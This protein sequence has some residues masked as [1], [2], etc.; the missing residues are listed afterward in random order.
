MYFLVNHSVQH[1]DSYPVHDVD[2]HHRQDIL[3][4]ENVKVELIPFDFA[5]QD[6]EDF[7]KPYAVSQTTLH[8]SVTTDLG[9]KA[10]LC[11]ELPCN[12][13]CAGAGRPIWQHHPESELFHGLRPFQPLEQGGFHPESSQG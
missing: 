6:A 10:G 9:V 7:V 1:L 3:I 8:A 5:G 4:G 2:A 11:A 12:P 13:E